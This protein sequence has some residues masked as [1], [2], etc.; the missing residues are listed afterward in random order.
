MDLNIN[1]LW[2]QFIEDGEEQMMETLNDVTHN[3]VDDNK[4]DREEQ[5]LSISTKTM[6]TYLNQTIDIQK[7]F[8]ELPTIYYHEPVCGIIKKQIKIT[9]TTEEAI[10]Q[11]DEKI[12]KLDDKQYYSV[13]V[14][15]DIKTDKIIK[16][17]CKIN[18]GLCKKDITSYLTKKKSA[19][20]NCFVCIL[21]IKENDKFKE[22]HV[23][24]FNTGKMEIPG[25][26]QDETLFQ[27]LDLL[28]G[29]LNR[30][31]CLNN[32]SYFKDDK[33]IQTVLINS[34]FHCGYTV[35]RQVLYD[36]LKFKYE[37]NALYDPCKY[38]GV[39]CKFYYKPDKS[40]DEQ[41]GICHCDTPCSKKGRPRNAP[42]GPCME[43]SFMIFR[44][45][46]ILIVGNCKEYIL[47][48]IYDRIKNIMNV[49][50]SECMIKPIH[51]SDIKKTKAKRRNRKIKLNITSS[52]DDYKINRQIMNTG[53]LYPSGY[54]L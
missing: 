35:N 21:R 19:F 14:L 42:T 16:N 46:S 4:Y 10:Q 32:V 27:S 2:D 24:V 30:F 12:D 33:D 8:W 36:R 15:K 29:L 5:E 1:D 37:F 28:C 45:G 25:I 20:Y 51:K 18:I 50:R 9:S 53:V 49:E 39:Q 7:I 13:D 48:Q 44:T 23:K 41:D 47:R 3:S 54:S 40:Y 34:N 43:L 38:P 6:I 22:I 31:T 52:I 17:V 26:Q 11:I